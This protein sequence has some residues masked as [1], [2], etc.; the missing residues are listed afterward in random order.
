MQN[1]ETNELWTEIKLEATMTSVRHQLEDL[2]ISPKS[3]IWKL[4]RC[5]KACPNEK[6]NCGLNCRDAD[7]WRISPLTIQSVNLLIN[8]DSFSVAFLDSNGDSFGIDDLNR[9]IFTD[10]EKLA[11][12]VWEKVLK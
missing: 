10:K 2:G 9:T 12:V 11:K 7:S 1:N 5:C 6:E 3:K 4:H 8:E